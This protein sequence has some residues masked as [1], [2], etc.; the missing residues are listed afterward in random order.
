M[1]D[2]LEENLNRKLYIHYFNNKPINDYVCNH[3]STACII[4]QPQKAITFELVNENNDTSL[5]LLLTD[6]SVLLFR[7]NGEKVLNFPYTDFSSIKGDLYPCLRF[8][9]EG[10]VLSNPPTN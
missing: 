10:N 5:W 2:Y 4:R 1:N 7:M 3:V 6:S 8:D 9:K